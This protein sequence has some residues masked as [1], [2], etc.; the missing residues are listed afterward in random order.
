[1]GLFSK[2][3]GDPNK[4]LLDKLQSKV[5][6][7]N[8]KE[9]FFQKMTDEELIKFSLKL[10]ANY[11]DE[12]N[13]DVLIS[14]AFGLVR[15]TSK[16]LIG[17]RHFDVQLTGGLVLHQGKIAEMKTGE[18][19]TLVA[20]LPSYL[21]SIGGRSVHVV[22]VNDYLAK[23]DAE[24]MAPIYSFLGRTVGCLQSGNSY[25][26][27]FDYESRKGIMV[28]CSREEAYKSNILYGTN[29]EFGF[30]YLRDN[31]AIDKTNQVQRGLIFTIVD[32][33][34]N[35]LIDEARTPLIISG[36]AKDRSNEYKQ[37]AVLA[38]LLKKDVDFTIDE[39]YKN[40]ILSEEG[41]AKVEKSL[42][43]N[44][45]YDIE[46]SEL[47]HFIEN[48]LKAE[49]VFKNNQEY[50]INQQQVVL[51]D[52]FTGRLMQG[53][54][55]SDGLHQA[56][57]AKESVKIRAE[58]VTYATITLQNFFR[59]YEKL[60]GMTGTALTEAEEFYKIYD[61]EVVEVPTNSTLERKDNTDLVFKNDTSK[62]RHIVKKI[63]DL[64]KKGSPV[65]IGTTSI[66]KSEE[67][68]KMLRKSNVPHNVLNAKQHEKEAI[69]IAEAGK[70][71]AVTVAT[72][73]AGRGTDIVLGGSDKDFKNWDIDNKEIISKGG[74]NV[75]GT[76]RHESRR[77]DNQLRGR[78]G[79]QG[80]PGFTQ[81]YIS[82]EDD[83]MR[84]FGGERI[85]SLMDMAGM[86][87]DVPIE[88]KILTRAVENAQSKVEG[89]NF[90]I[91]KTLVEYDD[92]M[93]KQREII[94]D[95]RNRALNSEHNFSEWKEEIQ[96]NIVEFSL[97]YQDELE[98]ENNINSSHQIIS[99]IFN[100]SPL[101]SIDNINPNPL[102][103]L[104]NIELNIKLFEENNN[105][106][107]I[108]KW[109][110]TLFLHFIDMYWV[111]HLTSM[112]NMRQGIGLQAAGQ[113]NPLIQYKKNGF[114][115]FE[116]M[117]VRIKRDLSLNLFTF[118]EAGVKKNESK[119]VDLSRISNSNLSK[120]IGRNDPCPCGSGVKY[121]KCFGT[122]D[123]KL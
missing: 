48:A 44:N 81:F 93:N 84:R 7:I 64:Q 14:D 52:E 41:I 50:V 61:L 114:D 121:K 45:L 78:S 3:L 53:R 70:P 8:A 32:E 105:S 73:M 92:V 117:L 95:L 24:W 58:S 56:L 37:Y 20:T 6:E 106:E 62:F 72:N 67:I 88:N 79:R 115:M 122:P 11:K 116:D 91:R 74:L 43:V 55:L 97:S 104:E 111:E 21:N 19:K 118:S 110:S 120:K 103:D 29:N 86:E 113:R 30:D 102:S 89:L 77:I 99:R 33:V 75:I 101:N 49:Y 82:L 80:D 46:N 109:I 31:M 16:R 42:N 12:A 13:D 51:V 87:E 71:G 96:N 98:D 36:P 123:C 68:S 17:L 83:L 34:D 47:T 76:E 100:S 54:R 40:V 26:Y 9:T 108:S 85:K 59:M 22:T 57:E 1:M 10:S 112:D 60:S 90:E 63:S 4:K 39:K 38:R 119:K 94:Y 35:I 69:I 66:E 65:L 2:I 27:Q 28:E 107:D 23:R 25:L 5:N 18:G 15:E